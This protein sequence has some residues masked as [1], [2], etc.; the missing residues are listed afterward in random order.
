[1]KDIK[2]ISK[3]LWRIIVRLFFLLWQ[4]GRQVV[5]P[6]RRRKGNLLNTL[7]LFYIGVIESIQ[8]F[9]HRQFKLSDVFQNKLVR[10]GLMLFSF[11]LFLLTSFE[12][13]VAVQSPVDKLSA[14]QC[15]SQKI[16]RGSNYDRAVEVVNI[17][18]E[19]VPTAS[20]DNVY[21]NYSVPS[22]VAPKLYLENRSLLI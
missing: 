15:S 13:P 10:R 3:E 5:L 2:S 14:V 19:Y 16:E 7:F 8:H 22:R 12:Q 20:D 1:M 17:G 6:N 11:L 21:S 18:N 9:E 4:L